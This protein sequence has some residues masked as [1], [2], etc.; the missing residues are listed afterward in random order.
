MTKIYLSGAISSKDDPFAW[1]D[2]IVA[3]EW[4]DH[5]FINPYTLN[6][7][8]IGDD[9][10]YEYPERVVE[11]ALEEVRDCDGMFVHW[12]DDAFLIGTAMEIKEA[13]D[14]NIPIVIWYNGWRDN[15]SPWLLHT[16]KAQFEDREKALKV[17]LTFAGDNSAITES[18]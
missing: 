7:F 5:E 6:E 1:H 17:L 9:S 2:E 14:N 15:L 3:E 16:M 12:D 13:Y 8:E 4:G 11:P 18:L 10:I